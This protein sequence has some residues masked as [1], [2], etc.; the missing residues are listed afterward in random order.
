MGAQVGVKVNDNS[1][2]LPCQQLRTFF[3]LYFGQTSSQI[4]LEGSDWGK[5]VATFWLVSRLYECA[6]NSSSKQ[7]EQQQRVNKAESEPQG[8]DIARILVHGGEEDGQEG[9]DEEGNVVGALGVTDSS[10][11]GSATT[12]VWEHRLVRPMG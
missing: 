1:K 5:P 6:A 10:G 2:P 9:D 8:D 11:H 4:M 3:T 7:Q 12:A